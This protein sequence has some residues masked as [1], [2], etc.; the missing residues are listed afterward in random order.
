MGEGGVCWEGEGLGDGEGVGENGENGEG[1]SGWYRWF[2]MAYDRGGG[3]IFS[4]SCAFVVSSEFGTHVSR[5]S[6]EV[7]RHRKKQPTKE[8]I[9]LVAW[10]KLRGLSRA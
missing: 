3:N 5:M 6:G 9:L 1:G 7:E 2:S 4:T 10:E 8:L